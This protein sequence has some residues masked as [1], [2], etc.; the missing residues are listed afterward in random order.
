MEWIVTDWGEA[1]LIELSGDRAGPPGSGH[2]GWTAW[3]MARQIG[4]PISVRLRAP[5][6][7]GEP[8]RVA[9]QDGGWG[10]FCASDV[11]GSAVMSAVPWAPDVPLTPPV[12]V[13]AAAQARAR[14]PVSDEVH[15][16]QTCFI[17]G[18][19]DRS[20]GIHAGPLGDGR[21]ASDWQVPDGVIA[22]PAQI[23]GLA[24]SVLDCAA[25]WYVSCAGTGP[26]RQAFT[27]QY[28]VDIHRAPA[29]G[30][31]CAVVA[32]NGDYAPDWDGRKRGAASALFDT[33][34]ELIAAARSFWV[35]V[36]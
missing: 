16:V 8:M 22:S 5:I 27:V 10:L 36:R 29:P 7:L 34:G 35:A 30:E 19:G 13:E 9:S 1:G 4:Q 26:F 31:Q 32:W 6:P 14:F 3:Q 33:C 24:W 11:D 2:G 15:P 21:F 18:L 23:E 17:C 20:Q 25:H 28:A 12:S